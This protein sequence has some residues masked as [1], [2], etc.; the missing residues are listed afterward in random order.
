MIRKLTRN[1]DPTI[2]L[3]VGVMMLPFP[4]L[5]LCSYFNSPMPLLISTTFISI[6][7]LTHWVN[8][9]MSEDSDS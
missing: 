2:T 9:M 5:I 6:V 3:F 1:I 7:C 4:I 8:A